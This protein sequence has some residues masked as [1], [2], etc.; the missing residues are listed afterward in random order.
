MDG[1]ID[2]TTGRG[3]TTKTIFASLILLSLAFG[4][5]NP[6]V[7]EEP[8]LDIMDAFKGTVDAWEQVVGEVPY[9]AYQAVKAI[10]VVIV[11]ELPSNCIP[12]NLPEG[13]MVSGCHLAKNAQIYVLDVGNLLFM[14]DSLKHEYI[15]ALSYSILGYAD[16]DHADPRLWEDGNYLNNVETWACSN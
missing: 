11:D 3:R 9:E 8:T 10:P 5:T 4:C 12:E 13:K 15:H 6:V 14:E 2:Q 1:R 7:E 16:R